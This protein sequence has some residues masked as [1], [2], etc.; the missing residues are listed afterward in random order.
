MKANEEYK[1]RPGTWNIKWI[2]SRW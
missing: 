2:Y 1:T